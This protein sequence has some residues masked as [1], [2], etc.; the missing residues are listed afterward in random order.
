M[1]TAMKKSIKSK[2]FMQQQQQQSSQIEPEKK[3]HS[4]HNLPCN[5]QKLDELDSNQEHHLEIQPSNG[6]YE[7]I[8][9]I[10]RQNNKQ[11]AADITPRNKGQHVVPRK[12]GTVQTS[13]KKQ[14]QS[15][16]FQLGGTQV[17]FSNAPRQG[18]KMNSGHDINLP[19]LINSTFAQG[20][21]TPF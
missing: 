19:K 17:T 11:L 8:E 6:R 4:S 16:G 1:M 10:D 13:A 9:G 12:Q 18:S 7:N 14:L 2:P 21:T 15:G 20:S 3:I 5:L